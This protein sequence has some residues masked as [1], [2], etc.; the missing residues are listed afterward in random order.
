M[1]KVVI[2]RPGRQK[3]AS[4]RGSLREKRVIAADGRVVIVPT[5]DANSA[6]FGA[7]LQHLFARNV[8][9]AR[10]DNKRRFGSPDRVDAKS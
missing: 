3:G 5:I 9:K 6:T 4:V 10:R 8:A 1:A 2:G 7:D